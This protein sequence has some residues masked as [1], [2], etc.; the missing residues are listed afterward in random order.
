MTGR[1]D[2]RPAES[3]LTQQSR[4]MIKKR[5]FFYKQFS[6]EEKTFS[7]SPAS[8]SVTS[9]TREC[10]LLELTVQVFYFFPTEE[11]K[12]KGNISITQLC[13]TGF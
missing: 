7:K 5:F 10:T 13:P 1:L 6:K 8:S 2:Y 11:K 4:L 3:G 12:K 9:V